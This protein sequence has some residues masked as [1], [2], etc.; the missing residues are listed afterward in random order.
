[1]VGMP[2]LLL[3][4]F[5]YLIYRGLRQKALAEQQAAPAGQPD[6]QGDRS[7]SPRSRAA[8]S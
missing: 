7:C 6:G 8:D 4:T 3:G 5:G 2:Y 1:M